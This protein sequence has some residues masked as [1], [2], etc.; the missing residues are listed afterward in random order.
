MHGTGFTSLHHI[1]QIQ[2]VRFGH[3]T[4]TVITLIAIMK[5]EK[6]KGFSLRGFT[7]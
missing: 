4:I 3:F 5:I 6:M 7:L 1:S 2:V